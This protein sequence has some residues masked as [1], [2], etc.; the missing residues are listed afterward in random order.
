MAKAALYFDFSN[1]L[2]PKILFAFVEPDP[3]NPL[4]FL[5]PSKTT[6]SGILD[7]KGVIPAII[8]GAQTFFSDVIKG[9]LQEGNTFFTNVFTNVA[10]ELQAD[11][12]LP[13]AE[14]ILSN[15]LTDSDGNFIITPEEEKEVITLPVFEQ[16]VLALLNTNPS[17]LLNITTLTEDAQVVD[18]LLPA[19]VSEAI[20]EIGNGSILSIFNDIGPVLEKACVDAL[21]AAGS[22]FDPSLMITALVQPQLFGMTLGPP[23]QMVN[24]VINKK[25]INFS[26]DGSIVSLL[27]QEATAGIAIPKQLLIINDSTVFDVV[28]PFPTSLL[29]D[30]INGTPI[31]MSTIVSATAGWEVY[32]SVT[33]QA[34]GTFNLATATGYIFGPSTQ[35]PDGSYNTTPLFKQDV[36]NED[37]NNT[38]MP[39]PVLQ[40]EVAANPDLIGVSSNTEY[41]DAE[42]YGGILFSGKLSLP[43]LIEDPVGF[44]DSIPASAWTKGM[45]TA[46]PSD[47]V[48]FAKQAAAYVGDLVSVL[49]TQKEWGYLNFYIPAPTVL[50]DG[51]VGFGALPYIEGYADLKLFGLDLGTAKLSMVSKTNP[52]GSTD[53]GIEADITI[54][55]LAGFTGTATIYAQPT[56]VGTFL[57]NLTDSP[58]LTTFVKPLLGSA[59]TSL[60]SA[61]ESI[62][63]KVSLPIPVAGVTGEV[64]LSGLEKW[65]ANSLGLPS[66][67]F[68]PS[69]VSASVMIGL[70][71][72]GFDLSASPDSVMYTGGMTL[73]AKLNIAGLVNNAEFFF[74]IQPFSF[75][76]STDLATALIPNFEIRASVQ[77]LDI[78]LMGSDGDLLSLDNFLIDIKKDDTGLYM[79][80]NGDLYLLGSE[81]TAAGE[82]QFNDSGLWGSLLVTANSGLDFGGISFDGIFSADL[83]LTGSPQKGEQGTIPAL[84]A[85]V[86][87]TGSLSFGPLSADGTFRFTAGLGGVTVLADAKTSM[88]PLGEVHVHGYMSATSAGFV[89]DLYVTGG[90]NTGLFDITGTTL[91]GINTTS[92]AADNIPADTFEFVSNGDLSVL[93]VDC[94]TGTFGLVVNTDEIAATFTGDVLLPLIGKLKAFGGFII[95]AAGLAGVLSVQLGVGGMT[96]SGFSLS[97]SAELEINTGAENKS[98]SAF[99]VN[100]TTGAITPGQ[101]IVV[102]ASSASVEIGGRLSVGGVFSV[103]GDFKAA[104]SSTEFVMQADAAISVFGVTADVSGAIAVYSDGISAAATVTIPTFGVPGLFE[105]GAGA[106]LDFNTRNE[107]D[108]NTGVPADTFMIALSNGTFTILGM[109]LHLNYASLTVQD[110]N[111]DID[112]PA[113][114]LQLSIGPLS[115]S[116]YGF[117]DSDGQFDLTGTLTA[118]LNLEPAFEYSITAT[119]TVNNDGF[120]ASVSGY[121]AVAYVGGNFSGS[122]TIDGGGVS[123]SAE[124]VSVTFGNPGYVTPTSES[125][126]TANMPT[127]PP[128]TVAFTPPLSAT[129]GLPVTV[130]ALGEQPGSPVPATD[131]DYSY[132]VLRPDGTTLTTGGGQSLANT[133]LGI[134][135]TPDT[136]G[137]YKLMV[138][139]ADP[140]Y[141]TSTTS[142][143][144]IPVASLFSNVSLVSTGAVVYRTPSTVAFTPSATTVKYS[145]DFQDDGSFTDVDDVLGSSSSQASYTF[146]HPGNY[147]VHARITDASGTSEDYTTTLT[148]LPADV[149]VQPV[150]FA[151][152]AGVATSQEVATFTDPNAKNLPTNA[153]A[154]IS[155]GDGI[156]SLGTIQSLGNNQFEVFGAHVYAK[157]GQY[158]LTVTVMDGFGA[159]GSDLTYTTAVSPL[160]AN[161]PNDATGLANPVGIAF[162]NSGN[163]FVANSE[164]GVNS[165]TKVTTAGV[166]SVFATGLHDPQGVAF[167]SSGNLYV[168][169]A[170]N[171]TISEIAPGGTIS[172]FAS[173]LHGP[174]GLAF[175]SAG[176]LY[177]SC[178]DNTIQEITPRGVVSTFA[179]GLNGPTALAFDSIGN[180][181]VANYGS[182]QGTTISRITPFGVVST[183]ATG[184]NS[185]NGLAFDSSGNLYV[186]NAGNFTISKI[187]PAGSS[188]TT[189]V[190]SNLAEPAAL[191]F[192]RAGNLYVANYANNSISKVT[193]T[194]VSPT[195]IAS[196]T[197]QVQAVPLL[198]TTAGTSFSGTVGT[199]T[200]A[201]GFTPTGALINWGDGSSSDGT[202]V[203]NGGGYNITGS[204][205]YEQGGNF[206]PIVQLTGAG[207]SIA[208]GGAASGS[209]AADIDF[210]GGSAAS[211]TDVIT[212]TNVVSP[213]PLAVLQGERDGNFTYSIPNLVPGAI[214][215][216]RLQFDDATS[217]AAGQRVFSVAINGMTAL[218][219]FDIFAAAGGQDKDID[220][221]FTVTADSS[222]KITIAFT[223]VT[224][225]AKVD[226]VQV[227]PIVASAT[228]ALTAY[229][230]ALSVSMS[231]LTSTT[232]TVSGAIATVTDANPY[233]QPSNLTAAINWGDGSTTA[234]VITEVSN[235]AFTITPSPSATPQV[236]AVPLQVAM[237][238]SSFSG[239]VGTFT[240]ADGFTATGALINWGDGT[241][242]SVGSIV[243]DGMGGYNIT[244]SHVYEQNG[245]YTPTVLLTG[246]GSHTYG[247][248][249]SEGGS[250]PVSV[251]VSET[252]G[253]G[254][255]AGAT[256]TANQFVADTDY[257]GGATTS[258]PDLI[259]TGFVPNAAPRAVYQSQRYG[260]FTYTIPNE[261]PGGLYQVRL[262]FAETMY[263]SE[264][265]RLFDVAINGTPVLTDFDVFSAADG[266]NNALAET[267]LANADSNGDITIA[268]SNVVSLPMVSGIEITPA[269]TGA[270][271]ATVRGNQL[272]V[273]GQPQAG[274]AGVAFATV[275]N[276][277]VFQILDFNGDPTTSTAKVTVTANGPGGFSAGS[278]TSVYAVNGYATFSNLVLNQ[279]GTYTITASAN[280]D[281]PA[282]TNSFM[283][284]ASTANNLQFVEVPLK[285]TAGVAI[286]PAVTVAVDDV[287]GNQTGST[288]SVGLTVNGPGGFTLGSNASVNAV[289]GLATFSNLVLTTPGVYTLTAASGGLTSGTSVSFI[290]AGPPSIIANPVTGLTAS[291]ATLDASVNPNSA[292]T[293]VDFIYGTDPTLSSGTTTV[294]V[295]I[296]VTGVSPVDESF[297][298]TGLSQT[299][300]YYFEEEAINSAGTT[301]TSPIQSFTTLTLPDATTS[302][303]TFVGAV[304]LDDQWCRHPQRL[305]QLDGLRLWDRSQPGDRGHRRDRRDRTHRQQRRSRIAGN[306]RPDAEHRLLLQGS[307]DQRR[308]HRH[309]LRNELHYG[310][311]YHRDQL[312]GHGELPDH[313]EGLGAHQSQQRHS[314]RRHRRREQYRRQQ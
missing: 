230:A 96:G 204:H 158:P 142:T 212:T 237:A 47:V 35:N 278:T 242:S 187:T 32:L 135:F 205:V 309:Q 164:P 259:N 98:I 192:D 201:A 217:T 154:S 75:V 172:T 25:G 19:V 12:T 68:A 8:I 66:A 152:V 163:L 302:A 246:V 137:N 103:S 80:L 226:A 308:G 168:A 97:G 210:S 173:G 24:L 181:Y 251:T 208:S 2:D 280:G 102:P 254:I 247:A 81:F 211:T 214:Y 228:D 61:L 134:T 183:F 5:F 106:Q 191:A 14:I 167:D 253:F 148:V 23:T 40:A 176:N 93:G 119:A 232:L 304:A 225:L 65:L 170:G 216:V 46:S 166:V 233:D 95:D 42:K 165:I 179:S 151:P 207:L 140:G 171:G 266:A 239:T 9:E 34:F 58:F 129:E 49:S 279:T 209:Y 1:L 177:V 59:Y 229:D 43:E 109:G 257:Q 76:N 112:V 159:S 272:S 292:A 301:T 132:T 155:W 33:V 48:T 146:P 273:T 218:S 113:P 10:G 144:T 157:S 56:D 267:F 184:L 124:G 128:A 271:T 276:P 297:T 29:G 260:N 88:G 51:S 190:S 122:L 195:T 291:T 238:G 161:A 264:G 286:S 300:K 104:I 15:G 265:Q 305:R 11:H 219:N 245:N 16:S 31:N 149:A 89:S 235:G 143:I 60:Q 22:V 57:Y 114:G 105:L 116:L 182:D 141:L 268:F 175:D 270:T 55:W 136:V 130:N 248:G 282:T 243:S 44:I 287:F 231:P 169:N 138:T 156:T 71:T 17:D 274:G 125:P 100:T 111:W 255:A 6:I 126:S 293:T 162:D 269:A 178:S 36:I 206:T 288:A 18:A 213:A 236:Q 115:G 249:Y 307:R 285:D 196:A 110:G 52:D 258:S 70:Y 222:G 224:G 83:N 37:P 38:G 131:E 101:T 290:V 296:G 244:G 185:P 120:S 108:P 306:R 150:T 295:A 74:Q 250:F 221:S 72:P 227:L 92:A 188:V 283:I 310:L 311:P 284:G 277:V 73:D 263:T 62:E 139:A 223:S 107:T 193:F 133:A 26:Y 294:P 117:L 91:L 189:V 39:D 64:S 180:L 312:G 86:F 186:A 234:G 160:A 13:L 84:S 198:I 30:L 298:L 127:P 313:R 79:T 256:A 67:V 54:P 27:Q 123:L 90:L 21:N 145:Y 147:T 28:L 275:A 289:S 314:H 50:P 85:S 77:S 303:A 99:T 252:S 281:V 63:G 203:S 199:Y 78:P 121:A 45:P 194:A 299:T 41:I 20:S 87:A 4:A 220:H 94:L 3:S 200:S 215:D 202:L 7:F 174:Q 53:E 241:I 197:P 82:L 261:T 240:P 69:D 118:A 262:D 153:G